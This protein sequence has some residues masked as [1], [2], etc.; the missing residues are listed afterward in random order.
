MHAF[1]VVV[2]A[3]YGLLIGS[4]INAWAYRLPRGI[5]VAKGRSFCPACKQPIRAYDNIPLVSWL[6]LRGKCRACGQRISVRY[7][8][9]EAIVAAL[10][11]VVAV[12]DGPSW[13]LVPHLLF[14]ATL[15]LVSEVD[16]DARIIPDVVIL[17]VAAL[18]LALMVALK[19]HQWV[20]WL[21]AGLGAA[22][23]LF[24]IGEVYQRLRGVTGMG[25]G[26]VKMALCMGFYLGTA[27]VPALFI[28]F[29]VGAIGGVVLMTIG[30]RG[31]K[32]AVPFGPFLALGA[33]VALF[34]GRPLIHAYLHLA[35]RR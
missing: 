17:P 11:A 20:E 1:V 21:V 8:L 18:G 10:F 3:V 35:L 6:I 30:G 25:M 5:S 14:V 15:V 13:M 7:P 28:A 12:V 16:L 22:I 26:D 29:V 9:G 32:T 4:F 23:G 24:L 27:V 31:G 2:A 34:V 19:P 33:V